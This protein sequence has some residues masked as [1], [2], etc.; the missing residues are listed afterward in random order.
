MNEIDVPTS[1][2]VSCPLKQFKQRYLHK[3]CFKCEYFK[4]VASLT[5]ATEMNIKDPVTSEATGTRPIYWHEKNM[6]R[7]AFPM[8]RRCS[9]ISVV[10]E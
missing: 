9:D 6:I 2:A 7:C 8:T 3:G 5:D 10:E 4:G 1:T